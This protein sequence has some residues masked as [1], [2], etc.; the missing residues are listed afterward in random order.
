MSV[1]VD[2]LLICLASNDNLIKLCGTDTKLVEKYQKVFEDKTLSMDFDPIIVAANNIDSCKIYKGFRKFDAKKFTLAFIKNRMEFLKD[3][4]FKVK[5][6]SKSGFDFFAYYMNYEDEIEAIYGDDDF[7]KAQKACIHYI[8]FRKEEKDVD[9]L[10][11][12]ASF[13]DVIDIL[14]KVMPTDATPMSWLKENAREH[15]LNIGKNEIMTGVREIPEIFNAW[16]Y[17][18]SYAGTKD[19]FWNTTRETLD[20]I[21]ATVAFITTGYKEGL[22]RDLFNSDVYLA[23]YPDNLLEDIY[24]ERKISKVK[25]AKC[26]LKKFPDETTLDKFDPMSFSEAHG[27]DDP[28][29]SCKSFVDYQTKI[30]SKFL[31]KQ[32]KLFSKVFGCASAAKS[33][34]IVQPQDATSMKMRKQL[35]KA[36]YSIK[37]PKPDEIKETNEENESEKK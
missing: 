1:Q 18:A 37:T 34:I 13:D 7:T 31:K 33:N 16:L 20:E 11:Y 8:E 2:D 36:K 32:S 19:I 4:E 6:M 25:V 3:T 24:V 21:L 14:M 27:L 28:F 17:I 23:N 9:Y 35:S 12:A 22:S 15:Y 10:R 30:Y 5:A 29:N 26:W